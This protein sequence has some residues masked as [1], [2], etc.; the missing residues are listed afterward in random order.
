MDAK[1]AI[2]L[3]K[4]NGAVMVD[5]KFI[6]LPGKWQHTSIPFDKLDES[7]FEDGIGFDGSSIRGFQP[8]NESDMLLIPDPETVVMDP[9]TKYPTLS[10]QCTIQ[11]TL[12]RQNYSRD[13]RHIALKAEAYLKST[14]VA[15]T[16]F[17]GPEAEFFIL[18][19]ARF[20]VGSNKSFYFLDSIEA[21]WNTGKEEGPNLGHKIRHKEGYFPCPPQDTLM[22][23][24]TEIVLAG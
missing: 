24:R 16:A 13:P 15:D 9:F 4:K 20:E 14:G 8:I 23:V 18:D 10:L 7:S 5:L 21:D 19:E 2:E 3:G 1:Q 6:D 11:D 17:F 12:T 22:D